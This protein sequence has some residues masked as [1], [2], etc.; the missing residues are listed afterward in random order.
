MAGSSDHSGWLRR[1]RIVRWGLLSILVLGIGSSVLD[2]AGAFGYTGSDTRRF[3]HKLVRVT[4]A[5][6]GDTLCVQLPD[7]DNETTV[8]LLGVDAPHLPGAHWSTNAAKY[9]AARTTGRM[10]TL[11][12]DPIGWRNQRG[13]LLAY[14]F[15]TD[16]DNLNLDIIHDGQ[17]YADRR[18][19][20]SLHAPLEEAEKEARLKKRGLWKDLRDQDQ[21]A[22]RR[23][24]LRS[25]G[26]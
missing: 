21:P 19:Q 10:V 15:I 13:E 12:L 18:V 4:R 2:H 26:Y 9:T 23:E 22:W 6:D 24:W 17:A 3:D 11:R 7:E 16:A 20:H 1:R 5:I 25:R 14:V 8:H